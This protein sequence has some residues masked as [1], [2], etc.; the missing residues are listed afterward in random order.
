MGSEPVWT[1]RELA[2]D[3]GVTLRT[4]RHYEDL[5]LLSPLR[6]GTRRV[7]RQRDRVRLELVLR[8]R[9]LGFGL[10]EIARI[11]NMYD[12]PPGE[13]GQLDY[14]LEQIDVRRQELARMRADIDATESDLV[15]VAA[16]CRET[17]ATMTEA[18]P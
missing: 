16:R 8:G 1:I 17:L 7:Y 4:L 12:E 18:N 14:L 9:R 5:R 10:D 13:A 3:Y 6:D 2:D 11:V 15:R